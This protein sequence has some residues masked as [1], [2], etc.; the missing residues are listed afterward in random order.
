MKRGILTVAVAMIMAAVVAGCAGSPKQPDGPLDK[1]TIT[2][3]ADGSI[4]MFGETSPA[5]SV[6]SR[7]KQ[8]GATPRTV[9]VI[10]A[11]AKVQYATVRRVIDK[12]VGYGCTKVQYTTR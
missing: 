4:T 8:A 7:L 11:G 12:V 10:K 1:C 9:V 6:S 3:N 5:S 2:V